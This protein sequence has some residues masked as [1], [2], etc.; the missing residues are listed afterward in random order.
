MTATAPS[1]PEL[2]VLTW[3]LR[4]NSASADL[5]LTFLSEEVDAGRPCIAAFQEVPA[6]LVPKVKQCANLTVQP[7]SSRRSREKSINVVVTSSD[8]WVSPAGDKHVDNMLLDREGRCLGLT[9]DSSRWSGLRF[10]AVH[11]WDRL[12]RPAPHVRA[13]WG[14]IVRGILNGFWTAGPLIV[15]G[16]LNANPWDI[17]VTF[18]SGWFASRSATLR[19]REKYQLANVGVFAKPLINLSWNMISAADGTHHFVSDSDVEWHFLDQ[20]LA[21]RDLAAARLTP[22]VLR[23]I[24]KTELVDVDGLPLH[25]RRKSG[26]IRWVYSDHLPVELRVPSVILAAVCSAPEAMKAKT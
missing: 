19:A 7:A 11:G 20:F 4:R 23:T 13:E 5:A 17:E 9:F 2:V 15:A 18:R 22:T 1:D 12:C 6:D 3:N 8:L 24:G 10:L 26:A 25:V 21:S 14:G 16:D